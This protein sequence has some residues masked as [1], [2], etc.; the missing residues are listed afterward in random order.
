MTAFSFVF[1]MKN[2]TEAKQNLDGQLSLA[3]LSLA[4][5]LSVC[6]SLSGYLHH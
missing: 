4:L 1:L 6:L 3:N 2:L 5:C